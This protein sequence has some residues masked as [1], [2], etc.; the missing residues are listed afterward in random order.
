NMTQQADYLQA[1]Q[2]ELEQTINSIQGVASSQINVALPANQDFALNN[3]SPTGA[4][5]M[6]TMMG[7]QTLSSTSVQA[8]VHLVGSSVPNLDAGNVTVADSS[9]NLLAGPGMS[10]GGASNSET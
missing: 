4:S 3:N 9:G 1:I 8:I 5:V 7:G 2:G 6:V 10:G